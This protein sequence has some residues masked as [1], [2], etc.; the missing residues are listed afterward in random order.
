MKGALTLKTEGM[1]E[2]RAKVG[3]HSVTSP[4][5]KQV[6]PHKYYNKDQK[7]PKRDEK[8]MSKKMLALGMVVRCLM[9]MH[10]Q[11]KPQIKYAGK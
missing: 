4:G 3:L 2:S 8:E 7:N 11:D 10:K 1:I 9:S 6:G 5:H